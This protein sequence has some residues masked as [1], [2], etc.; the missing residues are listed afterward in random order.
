MFNEN[1]M[2]IKYCKFNVLLSSIKF[3]NR[4]MC[5]TLVKFMYS[6]SMKYETN[7]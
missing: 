2:I 1:R 4:V 7:F 5:Y 6:E 3:T